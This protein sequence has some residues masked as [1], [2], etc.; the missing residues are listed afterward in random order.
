MAFDNWD[1]GHLM[2]NHCLFDPFD[3]I[4][5]KLNRHIFKEMCLGNFQLVFYFAPNLSNCRGQVNN[6]FTDLPVFKNCFSEFDRQ[7]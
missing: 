7:Y 2:D 4:A 6:Y 5:L 1:S 3:C